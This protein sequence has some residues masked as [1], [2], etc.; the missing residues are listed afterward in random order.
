M[1]Y[2]RVYIDAIGYELPPVVVTSAELEA[3][4]EPRLRGA[5]HPRR[6]ARGADRDRRAAVVGPG[7][8]GL[9]GGG[10]RGAST[11][12][13]GVGRPARRDRRPDLRRRLP[14]AVRAG[15]RLPGRRRGRGQ[16]R[17]GGLR[18]QQRLPRRAQRHGRHRQP[19]R[20]G[21]D[22]RG[23]GRLVRD[24]PRDQRHHDRRDARDRGRW[25]CSS[26]RWPRSPAARGRWPCS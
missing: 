15:D 7:L 9:R 23:A 10:R 25:R 1:R 14:R 6:A 2:S 3:R 26:T 13:G 16:P 5:A 8:P 24:G 20:A 11:R 22:P 18:R 21:P 19:D 17:R 12:S 4:L